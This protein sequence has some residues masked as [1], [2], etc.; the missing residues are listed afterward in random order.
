[1]AEVK[2]DQ[3]PYWACT[4]LFPQKSVRNVGDLSS[5]VCNGS[6]PVTPGETYKLKLDEKNEYALKILKVTEDTDLKKTFEIA[7]YMVAK[8]DLKL[9]FVKDGEEAFEAVYKNFATTTVLTQKDEKP[10]SPE[11]PS[12][13]LP[14]R[15]TLGFIAVLTIALIGVLIY[16]AIKGF[17]KK[18]EYRSVVAKARYAD[19]FMDFNIEL[20]ELE[21][22]KKFS[23]LFLDRLEETF[24]KCF[25]R[26][27]E[28]NVFFNKR[29]QLFRSLK[30]LGAEPHE[31]RSFYVLEE[32]YKKF[33]ALYKETRGQ[34]PDQK[35]D[36]LAL[37]K[38]TVSKLKKYKGE[39]E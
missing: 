3:L 32:E 27:F 6:E 28:N 37:S 5:L 39:A 18:N 30:G 21:N 12:Y 31:M 20:R 17:K 26:I 7:P 16:K 38:R 22:E 4:D 13:L 29:E 9:I 33:T 36:F 8:G 14:G 35:K 15:L 23:V 1:M 10:V 11:G 2:N 24:K 34:V 25:F 19:P